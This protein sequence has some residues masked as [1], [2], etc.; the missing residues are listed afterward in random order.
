[1][2]GKFRLREGTVYLAHDT[3]LDRPVAFKVPRLALDGDRKVLD[4][5]YQEARAA[6]TLEHP[7]L[8]P[9]YDVGEIDGT[10]YLTM[11]FVEGWPLSEVLSEGTL[12]DVRRVVTLVHQLAIAL[13]EAHARGVIHRDLK[14]SNVMLNA[15]GEP[16]VMD[17]GLARRSEP[18][19]VRL[20]HNGSL[21]GTP[22][23]MAPEQV[24]G[25]VDAQG[26]ACDIYA[27]GVIL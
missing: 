26:P 10:P 3:S 14:P 1:M 17:F 7:H 15:R 6:A 23:Y 4:R 24:Q 2:L 8:C 27:L 18:A 21:V 9:V 12:L 16:V 20:T 25:Q 11:A 19:A 13:Q 22:A 5:F